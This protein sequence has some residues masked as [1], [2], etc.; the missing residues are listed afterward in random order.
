MKTVS[1]IPRKIK[2]LSEELMFRKIKESSD[3]KTYKLSKE[4][5]DNYLKKYR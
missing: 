1:V 2:Y 3:V 5:L 4:E